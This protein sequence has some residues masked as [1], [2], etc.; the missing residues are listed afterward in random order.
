MREEKKPDVFFNNVICNDIFHEL[1]CSYIHVLFSQRAETRRV[2]A[3][4]AGEVRLILCP[5]NI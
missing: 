5:I 4:P 1:I 3:K 2:T